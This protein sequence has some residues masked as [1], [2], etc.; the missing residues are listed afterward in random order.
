MTQPR[1]RFRLRGKFAFVANK[2]ILNGPT[3]FLML[4]TATNPNLTF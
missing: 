3:L 4:K 2:N 1:R